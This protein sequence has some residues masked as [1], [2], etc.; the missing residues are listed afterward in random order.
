MGIFR[1]KM[2]NFIAYCFHIFKKFLKTQIKKIK[3]KSS[4]PWSQVFVSRL[5]P[6]PV[7]LLLFSSLS[8]LPTHLTLEPHTCLDTITRSGGVLENGRRPPKVDTMADG[9]S[10]CPCPPTH[11]GLR[12]LPATPAALWAANWIVRQKKMSQGYC[13]LLMIL[14]S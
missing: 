11:L 1:V 8:T 5:F 2:G 13:Q 7:P 4:F 6:L 10:P 3:V 12:P 14:V 9:T